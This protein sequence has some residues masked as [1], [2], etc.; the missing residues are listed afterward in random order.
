MKPSL[1]SL[2][3]PALLTAV[4]VALVAGSLNASAQ[5]YWLLTYRGTETVADAPED[6]TR[7]V[8]TRVTQ[9][10]L[11]ERA[12]AAAG[13]S[14]SNLVL[15]LH[16]NADS[17]GDKIQVVNRTDPNLFQWDVLKLYFSEGYTN[18]AGTFSRRFQY[19]FTETEHSRGSAIV[20]RRS[21]NRNG[22]ER[23]KIMGQVQFWGS[24]T[25]GRVFSSGAFTATQ[26]LEI[27]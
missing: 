22:R 8:T 26:P 16:D 12:A 10:D 24:S 11:V 19:V 15:V 13:V 6:A 4:A 20:T 21:T 18:D 7:L 5:S 1:V 14:T 3:K 25:N 9:N 17:L 27:P 23:V 2:T